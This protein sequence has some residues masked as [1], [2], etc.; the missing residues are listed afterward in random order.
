[1]ESQ[2]KFG[3]SGGSGIS[4]VWYNILT[5]AVLGCHY[6]YERENIMNDYTATK[7][8]RRYI[9]TIELDVATEELDSDV[10]M[11]IDE[12]IENEILYFNEDLARGS[13]GDILREYD[14]NNFEID[15]DASNA[16]HYL[17][18]LEEK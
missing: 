5:V 11:R 14:I 1:M 9:V 13:I 3:G 4:K 6:N 16:D 7:I 12:T 2:L 10:E 15:I 17:K 8:K 18:T